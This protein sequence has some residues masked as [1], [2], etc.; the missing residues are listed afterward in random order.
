MA[1]IVACPKCQEKL[2]VPESYFG[3]MVECPDCHHQF[4][5]QPASA[6]VTSTPPPPQIETKSG[7]WE[8]SPSNE[9][10]SPPSRRYD[11]SDDEDLR[12]RNYRRPGGG[13]MQ[14]HRGG[15][16]LT[17][18]IL[19][20]CCIAPMIT[21]TI[22]WILG[23]IDLKAMREGRMDPAGES[24]TRTGKTLGMIAVLLTVVVLI[25]YCVFIIV[26]VSMGIMN[27]PR[28]PRPL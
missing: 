11:D 1:E 19:S 12:D 7:P 4:P 3:Q 13:N 20:I 27:Q 21:G 28:Q 8:E 25:G 24:H 2:Q 22:A 18:G 16:I 9:D 17:L 6:R 5:A 14:A 23:N 10:R 15:L 26:M